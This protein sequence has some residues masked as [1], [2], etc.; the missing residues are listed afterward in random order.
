MSPK[1]LFVIQNNSFPFDQRVYNETKSLFDNGFDVTVYCPKTNSSEKAKE[2]IDGIKVYRYKNLESSGNLTGYCKEYLYSILRIYFFVIKFS[3]THKLAAVHFSNPPDFFWPLKP[4][5]RLLGIKFVYDQHDIFPEMFKLQYSKKLIYKFLIFNEKITF[6]LADGII[7]PNNSFRK[8]A[9]EFCKLDKKI[10][11]T[12]I[13]GPRQEFVPTK[14]QSL[15]ENYVNDKIVLYIG[16]MGEADGIENIIE[17]SEKININ[18]GRKDVK[19]ILVGDGPVR[20]KFEKLANSKGLSDFIIFTGLL[21]HKKVAEYLYLAD[22]CIVPDPVNEINEYMTLIKVLE[23]MKAEKSFVSFDLLETRNIV[24]ENGVFAK[25]I[26]DF[27]DKLLYLVDNPEKSK[28][29]GVL[30]KNIIEEKFLWKFSERR[31]V[32]FYFALLNLPGAKPIDKNRNN[33]VKLAN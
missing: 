24:E 27:K 30:N 22:V 1:I 8:R 15:I 32:N 12:V 26:D 2:V 28:Q 23:Y 10:T 18:A 11:E 31:L 20:N 17:L 3:L 6:K 13:N 4:F 33:F 9:H 25:D 16:L 7:F 14:N 19:F 21:D 5:L 29:I